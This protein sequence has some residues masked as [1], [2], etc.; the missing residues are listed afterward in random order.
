MKNILI[1]SYRSN[2]RYAQELVIDV[3]ENLMTTSPAKG[4]ENH[5]AFTPEHLI[6]AATLTSAYLGGPHE[7]H[8]EWET[9]FQRKRPLVPRTP[10]TNSK[11]YPSKAQLLNE[12]ARQH[13]LLE[14]LIVKLDEKRLEKPATWRFSEYLPKLGGCIICV[15]RTNRC[16]SDN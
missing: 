7:L 16:I 12:L 3:D 4:L 13:Q 2:L 11:A 1:N 9:L 10:E 15:S 5:A 14:G 6:S 8:P